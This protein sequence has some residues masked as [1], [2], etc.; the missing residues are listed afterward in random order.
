MSTYTNNYNLLKPDDDDYYDIS[1]F[2]ENMDTID[3]QMQLLD[4]EV[5]GVSEKIGNPADNGNDTIFG[6][7]NR[8]D[9]F[10]CYSNTPQISF[11]DVSIL[12]QQPAAI[13]WNYD[14]LV[15]TNFVPKKSGSIHIRWSM[16]VQGFNSGWTSYLNATSHIRQGLWDIPNF[17]YAR[18]DNG[19]SSPTGSAPLILL[20]AS[21]TGHSK[22]TK[23][24]DTVLQVTKGVPILF[25]VQFHTQLTYANVDEFTISY[26]EIEG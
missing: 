17:S 5:S 8:G 23:T 11:M 16:T 3:G 7:L 12:E 26:D 18:N 6:K 25:Y 15:I 24:I 4:L 20:Q 13:P 21:T 14:P 22:T 9:G 10:Y 19:L 2:N 1:D